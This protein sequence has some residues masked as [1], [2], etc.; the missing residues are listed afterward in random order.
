MLE[1][2]DREC[3]NCGTILTEDEDYLCEEC[4]R[5][6]EEDEEDEVGE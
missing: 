2:E 4:E 3:S 6:E 1:D 5:D